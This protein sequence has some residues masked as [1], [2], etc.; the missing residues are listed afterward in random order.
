MNNKILL[1]CY[2]SISI[3]ML[4]KKHFPTVLIT[5][6]LFSS[7]YMSNTD[8]NSAIVHN[9]HGHSFTPDDHALFIASIDQFNAESKLVQASIANN[10]LTLAQGHADKAA[11]LYFQ[12]LMFEIAE[13]DQKAA[14]DL[15]IAVKSLQNMTLSASP[16]SASALPEQQQQVNRLVNDIDTKAGEITT[17]TIRQQEGG[18]GFLDPV[19]GAIS[20][21]FGDKKDNDNTKLHAL[22]VAELVDM[23]LRNYGNAYAVSFDMTN[24]SNM[25]MMDGDSAMSMSNS[26]MADDNNSDLRMDQMNNMHSSA[27]ING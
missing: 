13:K 26:S 20:S 1:I 22:R 27:M 17:M 6:I 14:E 11:N 12:N 7:V 4:K 25:A 9:A 24:M 19:F 2:Y 10:N 16:S 18:L 3:T 5:V 21:I 8:I 15:S 23:V